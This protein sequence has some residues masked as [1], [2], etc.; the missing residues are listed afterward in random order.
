M[1]EKNS[2]EITLKEV[3]Q[4]ISNWFKLIA[5]QWVFISIVVLVGVAAGVLLSIYQK[6]KY[7]AE[8]TFALE[9][10]AGGGGGLGA[11]AGIA[12][13]FGIDV[14]TGGGGAFSGDNM[15][16]LMKSRLLIQKTLLTKVK[17]NNEEEQLVDRYINIKGY[18]EKWNKN[19]E[20]RALDFKKDSLQ[21]TIKQDSIL[22]ILVKSIKINDLIV[23]KNDKKLNIVTVKC[24]TNDELFSKYFT[25]NLVK[26]VAEFYI[27]TKTKKSRSNVELLQR[28]TDSVKSELDKEMYGAAISQDQ[29]LNAIRAQARV[30]GIKKQMNIQMLSAM[31][32]ELVKNLEVSK[33]ALMREEP[34]I[35]VIDTPILP[36]M[37]DKL[38]IV[39]GSILGGL[40]FGFLALLFLTIKILI[41]QP[42]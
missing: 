34:F 22:L 21:F 28:R 13:Q 5:K 10:K 25:E 24:T 30:L 16:E 7:T 32:G 41:K 14:G 31:Y 3:I 6:P 17:I 4:K 8:L 26:N 38:G 39:K 27:E 29:N 42:L 33:L 12:S 37:K 1:Q 36:L 18:R 23:S 9:E 20:L 35:Q 40:I 11:Y 15:L 19:P 2:E